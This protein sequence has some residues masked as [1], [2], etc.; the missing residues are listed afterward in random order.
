[1]YYSSIRTS[2]PVSSYRSC[3]ARR[4]HEVVAIAV[5]SN[6]QPQFLPTH[7][8]KFDVKWIGDANSRRGPWRG[9]LV[10]ALRDLGNALRCALCPG[11]GPP[12]SGANLWRTTHRPDQAGLNRRN[13]RPTA[14]FLGATRM[15]VATATVRTN[16]RLKNMPRAGSGGYGGDLLSAPSNAI[17]S[18]TLP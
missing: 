16:L 18:V 12:R 13:E 15:A 4:G 2:R 3:V 6:Q 10:T 1:V 17:S 9:I 7:R 8:Y 11:V 14:I 5:E